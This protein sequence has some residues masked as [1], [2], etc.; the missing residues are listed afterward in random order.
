M[1][2]SKLLL[3]CPFFL[4]FLGSGC[5]TVPYR[6]GVLFDDPRLPAEPLGDTQIVRG[7][8]NRVLD[9][10]DWI[11]PGSWLGKLV[12][13]DRRVD[14][15]KIGEET[16]AIMARYLA[17]N[18]LGHVKV[19][20]NQYAPGSEFRRIVGNKSMGAGWRYTLGMVSW[21]H[22]TLLPGRFFGGDHYNPYSNTISLYS[23]I[24][25]IA[26][27]EGG[28]AKDFADRKWKGTYSFFYM[29]PPLKLGYEALA[30]N[31]ALGYLR[32]EESPELQREGYRIMH[33]AYGTY[34]GS[35]AAFY[36]PDR[37]FMLYTGSVIGGHI[38]GRFTAA[39]IPDAEDEKDTEED[40]D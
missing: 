17:Y 5:A 35:A 8:P 37:G 20:L 30:S 6:Q 21:L 27:H 28:H 3:L 15:H 7:R 25:A 16:E 34:I 14:N 19:R 39:G 32:A 18:D 2:L 38:T 36:M 10:S 24:P 13:W 31:D 26:V 23:D 12:L 29:I 1:L 4:L 9:A 33:P 11:W 22:Y 40:S